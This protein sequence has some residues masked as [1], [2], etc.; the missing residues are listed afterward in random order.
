MVSKIRDIFVYL[1]LI[2][3]KGFANHFCTPMIKNNIAVSNCEY[4]KNES[5][6]TN[7]E[8]VVLRN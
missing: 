3:L 4:L 7:Y 1:K 2:N 6:L 5:R 8:D